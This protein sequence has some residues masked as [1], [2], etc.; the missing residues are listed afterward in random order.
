VGG[1]LRKRTRQTLGGGIYTRQWMAVFAE[2]LKLGVAGGGGGSCCCD[3]DN[4]YDTSH[5]TR[6]AATGHFKTTMA[7]LARIVES[8]SKSKE[9]V[10][11]VLDIKS[12]HVPKRIWSIVVDTLRGAGIRVEGIASF[13]SE[14]IR[15]QGWRRNNQ[16]CV[17]C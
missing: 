15:C 14:Y 17:G 2:A 13:V 12:R 7:E 3:Y 9:P 6:G 11:L 16:G 5:Y 8:I 1:I 10:G 4:N